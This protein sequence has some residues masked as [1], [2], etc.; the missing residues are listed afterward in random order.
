MLIT[1]VN[2]ASYLKQS[3]QGRAGTPDGNVFFDTVNNIIELI[4]A[5]ELPT[6][7]HTGMGGGA[8][9]A[10]Q[11]TNF[12]GITLRALYMFEDQERAVDEELRKYLRGTTGI[13]KFA[14][15]YDFLNGVK[16]SEAVLGDGTTD[17]QKIRKSGWREFAATNGGHTDLDRV[18]HGIRTVDDLESTTVPYYTMVADPTDAALQAATWTYFSRAGDLDEAVQVYGSTAYGDTT[19]GDFDFTTYTLVLRARSW[20]FTGV[21]EISSLAAIDKFSGYSTRYGLSE[22]ADPHN[23]YDIADVFGGAQVAPFTDM[24]LEKLVTPQT[25]TGFVEADG[26]FTWV[27]HNA[28]GGTLEQ[29]A[30]Y[31]DALTLQDTDID[32]GAGVY[33]GLNGRRWY[34]HNVEGQF[35]T[36][37]VEGEGLFIE[38]IPL[39]DRGDVIFTDDA[40]AEKTYPFYPV[41][42]IFVGL[43]AKADTNAWYHVFYTNGAGDAD[44]GKAGA[45]TVNDSNGDPVKGL[46]N[47]DAD[48]NGYLEFSYAYDTNTQGGL[49]AGIDKDMVVV[50][51]SYGINSIK[52]TLAYFVVTRDLIIDVD[53]DAELDLNA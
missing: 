41:V 9:D 26:D 29:C 30:A 51:E 19:A 32:T 35:I 44:Y 14:G 39:A 31:L 20:G 46:C 18:Y 23:T 33:I 5:D 42:K 22:F 13:Y 12:D 1:D 16:L 8:A 34:E 37:S 47:V 7:D 25:E 4:G 15:A 2:F 11:L 21:S 3:T 45:V 50:V 52:P 36:T 40:A 43:D 6:F 27:L 38:N 10:N 28:G 17:R 49:S 24:A 53:V 48:A